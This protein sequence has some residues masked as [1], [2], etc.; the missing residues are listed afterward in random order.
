MQHDPTKTDMWWEVQWVG[1][2]G[3]LWAVSIE[4]SQNRLR[5]LGHNGTAR[6]VGDDYFVE[7][8]P[9]APAAMPSNYTS[10]FA[11]INAL[12]IKL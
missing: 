3:I 4:E 5:I 7:L 12:L 11:V 2:C 9:R 8:R 10:F 6:Q 1:S